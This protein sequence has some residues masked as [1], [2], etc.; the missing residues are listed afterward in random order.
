MTRQE[1]AR[2]ANALAGQS[3]RYA[4]AP[5]LTAN[6]K[7]DTLEFW[8]QWNDPNGV[9]LRELAIIEDYEPYT[10]S[11]AWA[12]IERVVAEGWFF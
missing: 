1:I 8:L 10:L 5:R 4:T 11:E 6:S 9:H 3:S 12:A 7:L 2:L